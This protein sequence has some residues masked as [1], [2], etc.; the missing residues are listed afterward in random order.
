MP[1]WAIPLITTVLTP[2]LVI[3]VS[4]L[5]W[6]VLEFRNDYKRLKTEY[7]KLEKRVSDLEDEKARAVESFDD[8][9]VEHD[10][11]KKTLERE[12]NDH[13]IEIQRINREN[14]VNIDNLKRENNLAIEL[15]VKSAVEEVVKELKQQLDTLQN[16]NSSLRA[17]VKRVEKIS[18]DQL[19]NKDIQS[20]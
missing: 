7:P 13:V 4:L 11:T 14:V 9:K 1:D 3:I 5:S 15:R 16:E 12:R 18:T 6:V 8:E 2:F 17:Q 10:R 20:D 19:I